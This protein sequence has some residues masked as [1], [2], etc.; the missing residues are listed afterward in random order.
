MRPR[1]AN[2][3]ASDGDRAGTN[4]VRAHVGNRGST[5]LRALP[6]ARDQPA[7]RRRPGASY[8]R[9][10]RSTSTELADGV[11]EVSNRRSPTRRAAADAGAT[12]LARSYQLPNGHHKGRSHDGHGCS[13]RSARRAS[14]PMMPSRRTS[15]RVRDP[16]RDSKINS[17]SSRPV[18]AVGRRA[19]GVPGR[20]RAAVQ[21]E[22]GNHHP[23]V[24][25]RRIARVVVLGAGRVHQAG[26]CELGVRDREPRRA[27]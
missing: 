8:A 1:G 10:S 27:R 26:S 22:E 20:L 13:W 12:Q 23:E 3:L 7:D 4:E 18:G 15:P 9:R 5:L 16:F 2:A 14:L 21:G 11:S 24:Q 17:G 25:D 6:R 19:P